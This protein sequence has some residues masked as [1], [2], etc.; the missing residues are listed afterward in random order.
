MVFK[1]Y[2]KINNMEKYIKFT[3]E[4]RK[5]SSAVIIGHTKT[6]QD[7]VLMTPLVRLEGDNLITEVC[8]LL[9]DAILDGKTS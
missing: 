8:N 1:K 9:N 3:V 6:S 7:I 4:N 2:Q 5:Y